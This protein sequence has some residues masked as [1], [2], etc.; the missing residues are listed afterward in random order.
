MS[1]DFQPL[2]EPLLLSRQIA[3]LDVFSG[4]RVTLGIGL[5]GSAEEYRRLYGT[6]DKPNRGQMVDEYLQVLRSLWTDRHATFHGKYVSISDAEAFPKPVQDPLPIFV[7]GNGEAMLRRAAAAQGWIEFGLQPDDMRRTIAQL[8]EYR[9]EAGHQDESFEIARQFY[10]SIAP[11]EDEAKANHAAA[12]PPADGP[13]SGGS[14]GSGT[15]PPWEHTLVGTPERI[16]ARLAEYVETGVTEICAI[17]YAPDDASTERQ[18]RL[19]A[20]EVMPQLGVAP[21]AA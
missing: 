12:M 2:H 1:T 17:F 10:I 21:T 20:E 18:T 11:T 3:T 5:G 13:G 7:A 4:G 14:G 15:P 8:H 6:L 19:F 9:K 16:A